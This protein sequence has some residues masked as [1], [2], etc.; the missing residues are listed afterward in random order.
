MVAFY[1]P[2]QMVP[3]AAKFLQQLSLS[4][5]YSFPRPQSLVML[6]GISKAYCE[7]GE[8]NIVPVNLHSAIVKQKLLNKLYYAYFCFRGESLDDLDTTGTNTWGSTSEPVNS[9]E[10][11]S[12]YHPVS[13]S[14]RSYMR[15]PSSTLPP[16]STGSVRTASWSKN[17]S[18]HP[19]T[20]S[21]ITQGSRYGTKLH[22]VDEIICSELYNT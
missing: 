21:L 4:F 8:H 9:S 22:H 3:R 7:M 13:T 20:Q 12:T 18:A 6:L 19:N 15:A 1:F 10:K 5:G 11:E 14:N 2:A 16:P 17:P